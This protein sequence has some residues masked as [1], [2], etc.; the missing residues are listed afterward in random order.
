MGGGLIG[1]IIA[2]VSKFG[3]LRAGLTILKGSF[4]L[5][6]GPLKLYQLYSI[7]IR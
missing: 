4:M 2:L 1:R 7:V 5:L 6:K 3:L